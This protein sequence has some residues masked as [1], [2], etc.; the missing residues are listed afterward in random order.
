M[1]VCC[2]PCP[3]NRK[4]SVPGAWRALT[5][6]RTTCPERHGVPAARASKALRSSAT[7]WPQTA[8]RTFRLAR[9]VAAL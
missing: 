2:A 5:V 3:G 4:A 9:P 7:P 8:A 1:P 6:L